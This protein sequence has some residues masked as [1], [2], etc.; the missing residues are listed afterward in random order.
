LFQRL[1]FSGSF[2][3]RSAISAAFLA[4]ST[5]V[6]WAKIEGDSSGCKFS[7]YVFLYHGVCDHVT[8]DNHHDVNK[9]CT[10][11][12]DEKEWKV[13]R[14]LCLSACGWPFCSLAHVCDG[15]DCA[16]LGQGQRRN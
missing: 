4:I 3:L 7:D 16:E 1:T 2:A 15:D 14:Q 11:W 10:E 9:H 5:G 12:Q 13:S 8:L 6:V